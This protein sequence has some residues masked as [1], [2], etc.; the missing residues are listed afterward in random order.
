MNEEYYLVRP[1]QTRAILPTAVL[2]GF[3]SLLLVL[4]I[5]INVSLLDV[6]MGTAASML[7]FLAGVCLF[8]GIPL[9]KMYASLH[10]VAFYFYQD[11]LMYNSF[12]IPY[13]RIVKVEQKQEKGLTHFFNQILGTGTLCIDMYDEHLTQNRTVELE[14]L[15]NPSQMHDY[16]IQL[17]ANETA[18]QKRG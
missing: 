16:L 4:G 14:H 8:A 11:R 2:L 9:A 10:K 6:E 15:D 3:L 18:Y 13:D 17:I 5:L 7:F 1:N 12:P